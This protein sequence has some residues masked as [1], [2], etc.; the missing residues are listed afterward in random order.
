[1]AA[2]CCTSGSARCRPPCAARTRRARALPQAMPRHW[3]LGA[4]A[5]E[6]GGAREA[7]ARRRQA[8]QQRG[9]G[10]PPDRARQL[11]ALAQREEHLQA[12][13]APACSASYPNYSSLTW[14][15]AAA[16]ARAATAPASLRHVVSR[17][18]GPPLSCKPAPRGPPLCGARLATGPP[19]QAAELSSTPAALQ[20]GTKHR[21]FGQAPRE[22]PAP[23][24]GDGRARA[25]RRRSPQTR[26]LPGACAGWTAQ[27]PLRRPRAAAAAARPRAPPP[28]PPPGAP[29]QA[30][31]APCRTPA[32]R[33]GRPS[34]TRW[35]GVHAH[36]PATLREAARR[37]QGG[38]QLREHGR[39]R[40]TGG[41]YP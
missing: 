20:P 40:L 16:P 11:L 1:M 18:S 21:R 24:L 31:L 35:G 14:G 10:A 15:A 3:A 13:Q 28:A 8:R 25:R 29:A 39:C 2:P 23:A 30:R 32:R 27:P 38:S 19:A 17:R 33:P 26:R 7:V 5:P 6:R 9:H 41:G 4:C 12:V 34:G 36:E 37:A 22:R